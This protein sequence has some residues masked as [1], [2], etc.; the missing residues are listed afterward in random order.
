MFF[1]LFR[2]AEMSDEV[3]RLRPPR[4]FHKDKIVRPYNHKEAEG[5][6]LLYVSDAADSFSFEIMV[7][8]CMFDV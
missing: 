3:K 6:A 8:L 4:R 7:V 1:F 5:Y 2:I